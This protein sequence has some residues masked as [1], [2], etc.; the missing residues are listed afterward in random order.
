MT[1]IFDNGLLVKITEETPKIG[2]V[3]ADVGNPK[4][5]YYEIVMLHSDK[6]DQLETCT[7]YYEYMTA[8]NF[9]H[10]LPHMSNMTH[11]YRYPFLINSDKKFFGDKEKTKHLIKFLKSLKLKS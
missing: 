11:T 10:P 9:N 1:K 7:V 2:V 4:G 8:M 6:K 5:N 3:R